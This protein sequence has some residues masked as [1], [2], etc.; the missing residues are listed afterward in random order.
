MPL[1]RAAARIAARR[2]PCPADDLTGLSSSSRLA[3][4]VVPFGGAALRVK[5]D[6]TNGQTRKMGR[7][8]KLYRGGRISDARLEVIEIL[9]VRHLNSPM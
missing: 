3:A 1:V 4:A 7:N 6:N 9:K 5:I 8:S 2:E